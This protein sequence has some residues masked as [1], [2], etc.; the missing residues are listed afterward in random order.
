MTAWEWFPGDGTIAFRSPRCEYIPEVPNGTFCPPQGENWRLNVPV[1][2]LILTIEFEIHSGRGAI[3]FAY[4]ADGT[5]A[6]V[7]PNV[8]RHHLG[9]DRTRCLPLNG[10]MVSQVIGRIEAD[11]MFRH[12]GRLNLKKPPYVLRRE[13]FGSL[14]VHCQGW[15]DVE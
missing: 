4:R 2:A 15:R 14:L 12:R 9:R 7:A 1:P 11:Q 3:V 6:A 13:F 5:Q 8:L 10:Q